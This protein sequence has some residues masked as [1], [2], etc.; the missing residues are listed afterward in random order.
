MLRRGLGVRQR[1][2]PCRAGSCFDAAPAFG[3]LACGRATA[4]AASARVAMS[5]L[6]PPRARSG[7]SGRGQPSCPLG[8]STTLRR[9][10]T[11][12]G[13]T[14]RDVSTWRRVTAAVTASRN[15]WQLMPDPRSVWTSPGDGSWRRPRGAG[16]R[17]PACRSEWSSRRRGRAV[18]GRRGRRPRRRAGASR[19]PQ[20]VRGHL[21]GSSPS[22]PPARS[23]AA[24]RIDQALCRES[25][26]PRALR[27]SGPPRT[28]RSSSPRG[29]AGRRRG[30]PR[31][32]ADAAPAV[33]DPLLAALAG[34][35]HHAWPRS[36]RPPP[37]PPPRRCARRCRRGLEGAPGRATPSA[38]PP[39]RR[40]DERDHRLH[41]HRLGQPPRR[42]QGTHL[43]GHVTDDGAVEQR[44]PVQPG[45]RPPPAR[46]SRRRRGCSSSAGAGRPGTRPRRT[47]PP[48]QGAD[49]GR[50]EVA[51]VAAQ[52]QR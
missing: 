30:S 8:L 1:S 43:R 29:P 52:V 12:H 40:L 44:E 49:A 4:A 14:P 35:P 51:D 46:P 11:S 24:R 3:P 31:P 10:R 19:V 34:Q 26:P 7:V 22:T 41:R 28:P 33:D 13:G 32:R 2:L 17:S 27:N 42:G 47:P 6:P 39:C 5:L 45:R 38:P 50:R 9:S 25:G 23:A 18:P 20:G 48:P 16:R 21:D 15:R 36:R 37:A